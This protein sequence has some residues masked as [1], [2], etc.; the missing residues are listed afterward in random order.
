MFL[1]K[2]F[3]NYTKSFFDFLKNIDHSKSV[4]TKSITKIV[5]YMLE[6]CQKKTLILNI[7][8][9]E[10]FSGI[11]CLIFTTLYKISKLST[12]SSKE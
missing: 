3:S 6:N 8:K 12:K 7:T 9:N 4:I 5:L 1:K 2:L 10:V 11:M